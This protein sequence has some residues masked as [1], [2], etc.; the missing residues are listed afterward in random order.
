VHLLSF[1]NTLNVQYGQ[2]AFTVGGATVPIEMFYY[3][4]G[5]HKK[6]QQ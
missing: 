3:S 2:D 4:T 5:P 1:V 6:E